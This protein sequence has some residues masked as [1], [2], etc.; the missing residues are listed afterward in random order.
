PI[1]IVA[2]ATGG[3]IHGTAGVKMTSYIFHNICSIAAYSPMLTHVVSISTSFVIGAIFILLF[4]FDCMSEWVFLETSHSEY[5]DIVSFSSIGDK[6]QIRISIPLTGY[7]KPLHEVDDTLFSSEAMGKGLAIYPTGEE[8]LA[9]VNG[10][11]SAIFPTKH[12]IG[13]TSDDGVEI[14]I[15]IGINT[16]QLDG[17]FFETSLTTGDKVKQGDKLVTFDTKQIKKAGY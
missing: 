9:P 16:V 10:T 2:G 5:T 8:V 7:L 13:L 1:L 17:E 15:H 14:L 6:Q 11:V 4:E 12:A 3:A